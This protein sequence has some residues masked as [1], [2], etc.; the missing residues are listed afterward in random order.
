MK[1]QLKTNKGISSAAYI[2]VI[3]YLLRL[4]IGL[5]PPSQIIT[6]SGYGYKIKI[7]SEN[8]IIHVLYMDDIKLYDKNETLETRPFTNYEYIAM[9]SRLEKCGRM[10][11]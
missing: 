11:E 9:L 4:C 5:N 2:K 8:V 6:R 1:S 10:G 3:L 7:K